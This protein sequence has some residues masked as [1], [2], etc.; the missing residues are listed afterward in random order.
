MK[1]GDGVSKRQF[2]ALVV[3]GLVLISWARYVEAPT[4][5]NLRSALLDTL[6]LI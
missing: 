3:T 4:T 5:R 1:G 2:A 6:R